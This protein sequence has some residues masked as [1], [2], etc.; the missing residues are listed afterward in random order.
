MKNKKNMPFKATLLASSLS[1]MTLILSGCDKAPMAEESVQSA[2]KDVTDTSQ[3]ESVAENG[4]TISNISGDSEQTLGSQVSDIKIAGKDLVIN[5][6][7]N[8]KV[9]DVVKSNRAIE[10]L[11]RQQGGYVARSQL[12]N[13]ETH[14][15]TFTTGDKEVKLTT[16]YRE[17]DMTVRIPQEK[18]TEFMEQLQKQVAFLYYQEFTAEDVTLDIYR[19]RLEAKLNGEMA[20]ELEKQRLDSK[21]EKEQGSNIDAITA[22]YTARQQQEFAELQRLE[23]ADRVKF[24]TINL[25]FTQPANTYKEVS[26]N[27]D[28]LIRSEQ[29][30]FAT[31]ANQAFKHGWEV[32]ILVALGI[33]ELWWLWLLIMVSYLFYRLVRSVIKKIKHDNSRHQN[34]SSHRVDRSHTDTSLEKSDTNNMNSSE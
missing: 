25:T 7:A 24:S 13:V 27:L 28:E 18:V 23:V 15:Q 20:T 34:S 21:N 26:K 1:I 19:K 12:S 31:Q 29:P 33:I 3:M 5:A 17:A 8:F 2:T 10:T 14:S 4:L 6:T 11:T 22:T 16:Y 9:E 30:S 32:L